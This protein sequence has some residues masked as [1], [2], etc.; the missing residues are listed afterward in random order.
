MSPGKI[1]SQAGHAY[2][3]AIVHADPSLLA[4]YHADFP[5]SPGTKV[6]LQ[7]DSVEKIKQALVKA[8]Q[9]GIPHFL[10]ID[11]GCPN[12]HGGQ[13]IITALGL[14]PARR[15]EINHITRKFQLVN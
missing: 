14:G 15:A 9:A 12:F 3:G 4:E 10:V 2:V 7:T 5:D 8:Q 13:P 6:C 1:A 11:S